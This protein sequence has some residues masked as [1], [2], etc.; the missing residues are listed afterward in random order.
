MIII[1]I[2]TCPHTVP[3]H[4][5]VEVMLQCPSLNQ[6]IYRSKL[7][8]PLK[9]SQQTITASRPAVF[10]LWSNEVMENALNEVIKKE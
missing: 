10:K 5:K 3:A 7:Y 4:A 9:S 6:R 1:T 8:H 2:G